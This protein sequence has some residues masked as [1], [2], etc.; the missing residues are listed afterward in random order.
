M[1]VVILFQLFVSH[2]SHHLH[3]HSVCVHKEK[4]E[5][6]IAQEIDYE[7]KKKNSQ[8]FLL[9]ANAI[10]WRSFL[11]RGSKFCKD[12]MHLIYVCDS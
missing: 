3:L 8:N 12:V 9:K 11:L 5:H 7:L 6:E 10:L 2:C 1:D 4:V